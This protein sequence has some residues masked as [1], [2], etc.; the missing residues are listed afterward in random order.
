MTTRW[1]WGLGMLA[2][3]AGLAVLGVG[4]A[5][6]PVAS[7]ATGAPAPL[8]AAVTPTACDPAGKHV[9]ALDSDE[10]GRP[11]VWRYYARLPGARGQ[12]VAVLTCEQ[13][14]ANGDGRIDRRAVYTR[15]GRLLVRE[16]DL[17][18]DGRVDLVADH[19]Q[20]PT[21]ENQIGGC[22]PVAPDADGQRVCRARF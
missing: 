1:W 18:F 10:D 7:R 20:S 21:A 2:V 12:F 5:H 4:C 8:L 9:T 16:I 17:D 19:G 6:G 3:L 13:A 14:D 15:E 22:W 11:D